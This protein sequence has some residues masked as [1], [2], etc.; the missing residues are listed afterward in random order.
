MPLLSLPICLEQTV[1]PKDG[2]LVLLLIPL[3]Q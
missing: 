1:G 3:P 2:M